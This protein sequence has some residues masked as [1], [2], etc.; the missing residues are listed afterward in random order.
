MEQKPLFD[1]TEEAFDPDYKGKTLAV[2]LHCHSAKSL[3]GGS[4]VANMM[5]RAIELGYSHFTLSEHGNVN[6]AAEMAEYAEKLAK[7]GKELKIFHS[8]EGYIR[9]PEDEKDTHITIGF[10]TR[11]AYEAYSRLTKHIFSDEQISIKFGDV[12]P[13][14]T[15]QQFEELAQYPITVGTGCVGSWLNRLVL[16]GKLAEAK[17]RLDWMVALVGKDNVYDEFI[18][19]DLSKHY[20]K[21]EYDANK[22][23]IK[24]AFLRENECNPYVNCTDIGKGCNQ[25]RREKLTGPLKIK[26]VASLDSHYSRKK[27]KRVQQARQHGTDWVMSNFQHMK[28]AAEF[29]RDAKRH[30]LPEKFIEELIDNTHEYA[31]Q[32]KDY[33]FRTVK[34]DGWLMPTYSENKKWVWDTIKAINKIDLSNPIYCQRIEY[35]ISVFADNGVSDFLNYVRLVREIVDIAEKNGILVNVRGSAGGSLVYFALGISV[36]DPIKYDLQFERHLTLGRLR[37]GAGI[38]DVDLDFS[39]N[40]LMKNLIQEKYGDNYIPISIDSLLKPKSAIKDA[41]REIL[42]Y[43]RPETEALT[44][45]MPQ[46][47]QG[48]NELEWLLG[49][50]DDI[51]GH[52]PG[53]LDT[54]P[55]LQKYA[56]SNPVIWDSV[57][58]MCGVDRQ[59]GIHSCG[60]I[61]LPEPAQNIMPLYRVGGKDGTMATAFN[62]KGVEYVG[63]VKI[64][65]L[66][67]S[68][69]LSIQKCMETL[70][71]KGIHYSWG[72]FP[73]DDEVYKNI[74][75]AGNLSSTFQTHTKGIADLCVKAK[76]R[77]IED[78]SIL[79]ALYRP[80]CLNAMVDWDP[81]FNGNLVDYYLGYRSG[82]VKPVIVHPDMIPIVEHTAGAFIFQE[83]ILKTFRDIGGMSYEEAEIARRAIGKKDKAVLTKEAEKLTR[84][85]IAK[86]WTEKQALSL[87]NNVVA[88]GNYGFNCIDAT[89]KIQTSQGPKEIQHITEQDLVAYWDGDEVKYESPSIVTKTGDREVWEV[90]LEDG[91]TIRAT[92]DHQFL[93]DGEWQTL[94]ASLAMRAKRLTNL[95]VR[96]VYDLEMPSRSN[97]ILENG[98]VAHNCSHSVSYAIVSYATAYLKH[99]HP[100]EWWCAELTVEAEDSDKLREYAHDIKDF[101]LQPDI[102][103]SHPTDFTIVG[104]KLQAPITMLKGVGA[105]TA[106]GISLLL[107]KG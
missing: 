11:A 14:M 17:Q 24:Q 16:K 21:P 63:G 102:F 84:S 87:F 62:P 74:Y 105:D 54:N 33:T 28:G 7:K 45:S 35:E 80:S 97:F 58:T 41:E 107:K 93:I 60:L 75:W 18:V 82:R 96:P 52:I 4:T 6:S 83:Q 49:K 88:S 72:E 30:E 90:E 91:S 27:D 23:L 68:K 29:A 47:P 99:H 37:S 15:V 71:T 42:G 5:D 61:V 19:D 43:V 100:L 101:I 32:F 77:S 1:Y 2:S 31:E 76:P 40:N 53:Y 48:E 38:P 59:K 103:S 94:E 78:I 22:N 73:H 67:V 20:V 79:I 26:P 13:I 46:I 39:D 36:I 56:K 92:P 57:I 89:Q 9:F 44:K 69:M 25:V 51:E 10:K 95:G 66:G 81:S 34:T 86:G 12:K 98:M 3:D 55:E 104:D 8:V 70:K 85:C 50:E 64:D 65:V 106:K